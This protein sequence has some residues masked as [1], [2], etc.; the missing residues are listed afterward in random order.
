MN[1]GIFRTTRS[2]LAIIGVAIGLSAFA[3]TARADRLDD[4]VNAGRLRCGLMLDFPP[5]GYRD[6]D[7]NAAGFDVEICKDIA[8]A[9]GVEVELVETPA[10]QRIPALV[11]GSVDIVVAGTTPTLERAKT[12]TFSRPYHVGKLVVVSKD[13][14]GIQ[15]FDDLKGKTV[16]VV[17]G[18]V[19]ETAYLGACGAWPEGCKNLSLATNAEQATAVRQGRADA[20]IESGVFMSVLLKS[21]AGAGLTICCEVPGNTDWGSIAMAKGEWALQDW[22]NWF[23]FWEIDSGRYAELHKQFIGGPTPAFALNK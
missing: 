18:T 14:S 5:M 11:S 12:V 17:R 9:M 4:V 13:G 1:T 15:K 8:K 16:A 2:Q 21:D 23:V 7:G 6:G 20:L 19:P 22:L 10:S 3:T